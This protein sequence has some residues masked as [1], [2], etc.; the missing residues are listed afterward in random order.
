MD[1]T[2]D[3]PGK[4]MRTLLAGDKSSPLDRLPKKANGT[5][6]VPPKEEKVAEP[7]TESMERLSIKGYIASSFA[8]AQACFAFEGQ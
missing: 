4:K 8:C 2:K 6:S 3:D 7:Q 1:E 5:S